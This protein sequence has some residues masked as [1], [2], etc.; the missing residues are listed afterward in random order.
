MSDE[1]KTYLIRELRN[2]ETVEQAVEVDIRMIMDGKTP[3]IPIHLVHEPQIGGAIDIVVLKT[4]YH[5]RIKDVRQ[6][7]YDGY[8]PDGHPR[9]RLGDEKDAPRIYV[10]Q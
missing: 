1:M 10:V 6:T 2:G 5:Y 9:E 8:G 4:P 3:G 7:V